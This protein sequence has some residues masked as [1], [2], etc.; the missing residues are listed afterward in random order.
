MFRRW[1]YRLFKDN[2][3]AHNTVANFCAI[4]TVLTFV[5][6]LVMLASGQ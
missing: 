6:F 2:E 3:T 4:G 1:R 5:F